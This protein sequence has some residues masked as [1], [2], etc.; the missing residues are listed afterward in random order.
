M[1]KTILTTKL[2][3]YD[4]QFSAQFIFI[5]LNWEI[6]EICVSPLTKYI[7]V[8]AKHLFPEMSDSRLQWALPSMD[9]ASGQCPF[10]RFSHFYGNKLQ[11]APGIKSC[12][13]G[14]SGMIWSPSW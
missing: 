1:F 12:E 8:V 2:K 11:F 14:V 9:K 4:R 6:L 10:A 5:V 3:S 13:N 7:L